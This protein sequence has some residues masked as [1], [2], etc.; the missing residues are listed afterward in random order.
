MDYSD[1]KP[2]VC[3]TP[4]SQFSNIRGVAVAI[5]G[6][7]VTE[8]TER[9]HLGL[10]IRTETGELS[11]IHLGWHHYLENDTPPDECYCWVQLDWMNKTVATS[12]IDWCLEVAEINKN[13]I[14]YSILYGGDSHFDTNSQFVDGP[15]G[16]GLTCA[17]FVLDIFHN[18]GLELLDIEGWTHREGDKQWA[19]FILDM[20]KKTRHVSQEH[21]EAQQA[22]MDKFVRF[23][24]E[25]VAGG[26]A[27]YTGRPMPMT[28]A[29]AHGEDV[30]RQMSALSRL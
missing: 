24:P 1:A 15:P 29:V 19:D 20:L 28:Q 6:S 9:R 8:T 3:A 18:F 11:L 16:F 7:A 27:L 5:V 25:E 2:I 10:L 4:T 21:L 22:M 23:R 30:I 14:Q 12:I 17:T 13:S 26:A